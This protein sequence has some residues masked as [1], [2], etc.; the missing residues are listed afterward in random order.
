MAIADRT[1]DWR[2]SA[3]AVLLVAFMVAMP[4][5]FEWGAYRQIAPADFLLAT[6]M[7][8]QLPR[9]RHVARAWSIWQLALLPLFGFGVV[10][11]AFQSGELTS[12]A[13]LQKGVGLLVLFGL[14]ACFVDFMRDWDRVQ[15]ILRVFVGAVLLH[16]TLALGAQLLVYVGGPVIPL[17]NEP[18]PGQRIS[19]LVLDANAFGGLVALAFALHHLTAGT[20]SALLRGAWAWY[21]Y[22]VLPTTLLLTF[23]RSSWLGLTFGLLVIMLLRPWIGGRALLTVAVPAAMLGP[24]ILALIPNSDELVTRA[25]SAA[26]RVLIGEDALAGFLDHPFT[27]LGLGVY[28]DEYGIVVHNTALWFLSD[29]GAVG[30]GVFAGLVLTIAVWLVHAGR[31]APPEYR[32][33]ALA[34]LCGHA[35]MFG[36]SFGIEAFY[37]RHW[38]I[39]LAAAGAVHTL[40]TAP[41][42]GP[43]EQVPVR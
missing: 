14:F 36:V 15:W 29:F 35:V 38:W 27:G 33:I 41:E 13:L 31:L 42:P 2:R 1:G 19:G 21:G 12:Y 18:Y 25:S 37:Q 9:L 28:V 17:I 40:A 30:L 43:A 6:Y 32:P 20:P 4:L 8:F 3:P 26:S 16:A 10:V 24:L 11:A 5:Q 23:S 22:L 7:I 39:V 34:L